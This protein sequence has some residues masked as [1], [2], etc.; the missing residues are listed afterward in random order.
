MADE[1]KSKG[2]RRYAKPAKI[3]PKG[4][5][6][7]TQQGNKAKAEST[8]AEPKPQD[9]GT[10]GQAPKPDVM[11]GTDGISINDRHAAERASMYASMEKEFHQMQGRHTKLH[12]DMATRHH[13]EL[14]KLAATGGGAAEK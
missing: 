7:E 1:K 12:K 8:A 3:A 2:E 10:T 13:D 9:T 6:S 11:A 14:S 5:T 4:D